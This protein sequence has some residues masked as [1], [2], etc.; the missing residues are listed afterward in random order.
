MQ[1]SFRPAFAAAC[2]LAFTSIPFAETGTPE[3]DP[4]GE[5]LDLPK[6][7]RVQV[8]FIE[9]SHDRFTELMFGPKTSAN[10][11]EL[12]ARLAELVKEGNATIVETMSCIAKSGQKATTEAIREFIYAT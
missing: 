6:M 10:D 4:L 7:I 5:H 1:P 8:E 9:L 11:T 12:R 2:W 3:Y